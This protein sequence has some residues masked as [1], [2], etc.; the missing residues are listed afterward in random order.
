MVKSCRQL[1]SF[2]YT[3]GSNSVWNCANFYGEFEGALHK[4]RSTLEHLLLGEF[5]VDK[6]VL[7]PQGK[8]SALLNE[9]TS[10]KTLA[11]PMET[12]RPDHGS[13]RLALQLLPPNIQTLSLE[14]T[15]DAPLIGII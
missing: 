15:D 9:F 4:H 2:T 8:F 6:K 10:L 11:T 1:K 3:Y 7:V 13:R 14:L 12:I 5:C